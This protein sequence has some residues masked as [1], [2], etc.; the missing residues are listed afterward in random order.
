M[1]IP[2]DPFMLL[3]FMNMQLRDNYSSLAEMVRANDLD[4]AEIE[5]KLKNAGYQYDEALKQFKPLQWIR[6]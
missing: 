6:K 5:E 4:Q 3:S 2:K 1:T